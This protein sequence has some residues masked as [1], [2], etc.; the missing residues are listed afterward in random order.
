V[1]IEVVLAD[2]HKMIR[3][4]LRSL[5]E[6]ESDIA[7]VGEAADGVALLE[8]VARTEPEIAVVDVGMPVMNGIEATKRLIAERPDMK[9]IA[10]TAYSDKR[11]VLEMLNAGAKGYLV[12]GSAGDELPRAIRAV[13]QGQ[14]YLCPETAGILAEAARGKTSLRGNFAAK[15]GQRELEVLALLAE[16]NSSA[17]IA[18]QMQI[19]TSTVE[20]H[21][22]NIMRKLDLHNVAEL[23]KYAIREALTAG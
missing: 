9:V 6:K 16:G 20:V 13:A 14:S 12:K 22:R 2:D 3:S 1:S 7:V 17:A 23:T 19:A 10:L 15:L 5:L 21:R 18:A 4:A 8:L 11:F